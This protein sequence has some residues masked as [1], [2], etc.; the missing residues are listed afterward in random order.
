MRQRGN[1]ARACPAG[2]RC[3]GATGQGVPSHPTPPHLG[4]GPPCPPGQPRSCSQPPP[5]RQSCRQPSPAP[6]DAVAM[7]TKACRGRFGPRSG[8]GE[9]PPWRSLTGPRA[10][11][12]ALLPPAPRWEVLTR[13]IRG[14]WSASGACH[15]ACLL[16]TRRAGN[17]A[18]PRSSEALRGK[19]VEPK[20]SGNLTTATSR[21]KITAKLIQ[22]F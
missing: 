11:A 22:N 19:L 17:T 13:L 16:Q 18:G 3:A 5:Q 12:R 14:C 8:L 20:K 10:E 7:T 15:P 9:G 6:R 4:Q 2:S 1:R 21:Y